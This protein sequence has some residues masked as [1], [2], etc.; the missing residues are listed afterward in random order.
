M[1]ALINGSKFG[2]Q[3]TL[4]AFPKKKWK[5]SQ[6]GIWHP[7]SNFHNTRFDCNTDPDALNFRLD[8][9]IVAACSVLANFLVRADIA[10]CS[11]VGTIR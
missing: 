8:V 3:N 6:V 5:E 4:T 10:A 9:F 7:Q 1:R 2:R 11:A